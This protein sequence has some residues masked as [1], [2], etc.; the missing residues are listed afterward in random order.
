MIEFKDRL[1]DLMKK[2][3]IKTAEE[4]SKQLEQLNNN[5]HIHPNTIRNYL[6]GKPPRDFEKYQILARFFNVSTDYL[7]G[8]TETETTD[9]D[10]K[11]ICEKYGLTEKSLAALERINTMKKN[12]VGYFTTIDT[13]NRLLEDIE[14][15]KFMCVIQNI[16]YFF[17]LNINTEKEVIITDDNDIAIWEKP[18]ISGNIM[19]RNIIARKFIG[20][21]KSISRETLIKSILLEIEDLLIKQRDVIQKEGEK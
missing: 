15:K 11:T 2:R 17:N 10:I 9:I 13:V 1:K 21:R 16:D 5:S 6:K 8:L 14:E 20:G 3:G 18:R 12:F 19:G 4:L 7:Q